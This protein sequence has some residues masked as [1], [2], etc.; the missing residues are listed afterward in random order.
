MTL[1]SKGKLLLGVRQISSGRSFPFVG[2]LSHVNMWNR[3][4]LSPTIEA[5]A[6]EPGTDVGNVISWPSLKTKAHGGVKILTSA[7]YNLTCKFLSCF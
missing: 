5:M 2:K 4:F 1:A 7:S 3:T 6:K